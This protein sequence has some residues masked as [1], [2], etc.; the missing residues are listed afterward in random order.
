MSSKVRVRAW[1]DS[2]VRHLPHKYKN[3][4]LIPRAH[5]NSQRGNEHL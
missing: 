3:L 1:G 5:M 4:N 2:L